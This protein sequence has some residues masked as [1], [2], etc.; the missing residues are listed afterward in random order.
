MCIVVGVDMR[1]HMCVDMCMDTCAGITGH[2]D[3]VQ[4]DGCFLKQPDDQITFPYLLYKLG[5]CADMCMDMCMDVCMD[6]C[7]GHGHGHVHGHV[8]RHKA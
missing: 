7:N 5:M 4:M 3:L 2:E 8:H 1:V 6:M